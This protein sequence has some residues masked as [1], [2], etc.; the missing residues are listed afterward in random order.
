MARLPGLILP[1]HF[2]TID[3]NTFANI[4]VSCIGLKS[5]STDS[6]GCFLGNTITVAVFHNFGSTPSRRKPLDIDATDPP[7][8]CAQT[9]NTAVSMRN[10][11]R[12]S[13]LVYV[14]LTF[15]RAA[16]VT[17][18]QI[19]YCGAIGSL[20]SNIGCDACKQSLYLL[21]H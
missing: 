15:A 20:A 21:T 14:I 2:S 3:S 8:C 5:Y 18:T 6:G 10:L 4:G 11:I 16:S 1:T 17:S 12:P 9:L 19:K 7:R 13:G